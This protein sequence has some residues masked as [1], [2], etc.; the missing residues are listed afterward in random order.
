MTSEPET[1]Q[2]IINAALDET[3]CGAANRTSFEQ[4]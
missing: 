1:G 2:E 4:I 3:I